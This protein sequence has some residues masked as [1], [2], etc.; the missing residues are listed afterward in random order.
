MNA[1]ARQPVALPDLDSREQIAGFV[2]RFYDGLLRDPELAPIF[3]EVAA[4]DLDVHKPHIIDYWC[5]LL[6]GDTA[7]Q[8]HTMNIHRR[9]HARRALAAE[10]FERWLAYFEST[11]DA[12]WRGEKAERAKR[13][14]R[15]IAGNMN[16][17]F[18]SGRS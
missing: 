17:S 18:E 6:L 15:A 10:D 2:D 7:Y 14:A 13:V 12:G 16:R 9:L 11:V 3:L 5:K 8:R 4:V 1:P